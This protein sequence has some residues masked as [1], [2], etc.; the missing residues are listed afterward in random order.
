MWLN[1]CAGLPETR[2]T[3]LSYSA[4]PSAHCV[5]CSI[6]TEYAVS[7]HKC[8]MSDVDQI[9]PLVAGRPTQD[10]DDEVTTKV[11]LPPA[12]VSPDLVLIIRYPWN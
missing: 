9:Q 5:T 7:P 8:V 1:R 4:Y 12:P 3:L 2:P 6:N 10:P 11:N